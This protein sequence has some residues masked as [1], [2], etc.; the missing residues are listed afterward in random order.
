MME[1]GSA[2]ISLITKYKID[3][4]LPARGRPLLAT[5][6][7]GC[8]GGWEGDPR[9]FICSKGV[10]SKCTAQICMQVGAAE[11]GGRTVNTKVK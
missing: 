3:V 8:E 2:A 6:T 1:V 11:A 5:G 4:N 9:G 7:S 10:E